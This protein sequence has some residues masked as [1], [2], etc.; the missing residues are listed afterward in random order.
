MQAIIVNDDEI[1]LG[2]LDSEFSD[3]Q[4]GVTASR[5]EEDDG[6]ENDSEDDRVVEVISDGSTPRQADRFASVSEDDYEGTPQREASRPTHA[7]DGDSRYALGKGSKHPAGKK[8][9]NGKRRM[10]LRTG[11]D[12]DD[13]SVVAVDPPSSSSQAPTSRARNRRDFWAAK[14]RVA[15][16]VEDDDE[17]EDD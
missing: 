9:A 16:A 12:S 5:P 4:A 6:S 8:G 11:S 3:P 7:E 15:V 17:D 14:G 2:D 1:D 10:P 13:D